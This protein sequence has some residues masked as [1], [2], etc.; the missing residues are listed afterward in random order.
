MEIVGYKTA[1][2]LFSNKKFG[3]NR[4]PNNHIKIRTISYQQKRDKIGPS[5]DR[6]DYKSDFDGK[7]AEFR[8][9]TKNSTFPSVQNQ[10]EVHQDRDNFNSTDFSGLDRPNM[11]VQYI[12]LRK[13]VGV[14]GKSR[15]EFRETQGQERLASPKAD[16]SFGNRTYNHPFRPK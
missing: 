15:A 10:K 6:D 3:S 12:W 5:T 8:A 7:E 14:P 4:E 2:S 16:G 11:T 1:S 9:T 13:P